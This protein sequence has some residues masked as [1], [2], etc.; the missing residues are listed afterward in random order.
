MGKARRE[1]ERVS[2]EQ[3]LNA[4][5]EE[6]LQPRTD[7]RLGQ[8]SGVHGSQVLEP[9]EGKGSG[10]LGMIEDDAHVAV[11]ERH[12]H[13]A[14]VVEDPEKDEVEPGEHNHSYAAGER[15]HHQGSLD[16]AQVVCHSSAVLREVGLRF[17]GLDFRN[18]HAVAHIQG[19][20]RA[21]S[22]AEKDR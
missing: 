10:E 15:V 16:G 2:V 22:V 4:L 8:V 21:L 18:P 9:L 12:S 1:N 3:D 5:L 13:S 7:D 20:V 14:A 11:E 19:H 17:G 6:T